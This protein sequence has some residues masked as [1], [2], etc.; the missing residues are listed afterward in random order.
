MLYRILDVELHLLHVVHF[1]R[2]VVITSLVGSA[3][4]S[5]TATA[6]TDNV[7]H[8]VLLVLNALVQ[9]LNKDLV[10]IANV[11]TVLVHRIIS[12]SLFSAS[13]HVT[14]DGSVWICTATARSFRIL[15]EVGT[16]PCWRVGV[17]SRRRSSIGARQRFRRHHNVLAWM[18]RL[19][20]IRSRRLAA[21]HAALH[22]IKLLVLVLPKLNGGAIRLVQLG[23]RSAI[24]QRVVVMKD[25][26]A[27]ANA[28]LIVLVGG[29]EHVR[30]PNEVNLKGWH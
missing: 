4:C 22:M 11:G 1:V 3:H 21:I 6:R 18:P 5:A 27:N 2:G 26:T 24:V 8:F 15:N 7:R 9:S 16:L 20:P 17:L 30:V 19:A 14:N 12:E 23:A 29:Q 13:E 28:V 25:G 10:R